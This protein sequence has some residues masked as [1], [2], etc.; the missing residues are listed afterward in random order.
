MASTTTIVRTCLEI[1]YDGD[2]T[3]V[4]NVGSRVPDW[5]K[6]LGTPEQ[7]LEGIMEILEIGSER[8]ALLGE[9]VTE[10]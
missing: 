10:A 4:A 7:K 8:Q 1:F 2:N 5:V 9:A 3:A 6:T